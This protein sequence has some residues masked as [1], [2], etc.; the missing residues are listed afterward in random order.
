MMAAPLMAGNDLGHV[1]ETTAILTN[2]EVIAID[3]DPLGKQGRARA[4]PREVWT[5]P[6]ADGG[7]RCS[8]STGAPRRPRSR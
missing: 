6:L 5:K 2:R 8:S 4:G 3:Q 7:G 1:A